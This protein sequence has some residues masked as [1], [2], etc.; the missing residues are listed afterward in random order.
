MRKL[1]LIG[2]VGALL[3]GAVAPALCQAPPAVPAL[4]D[5]ER[6]ISYSISSQTGPFSVTFAL[7]GDG[8]DYQDWLSVT[9]CTS[10]TLNPCSVLVGGTDWTLSSAT[11]SL[12]TIPRPITDA[13]ITLTTARTGTLQ[14]VGARRPRRTSQFAENRGVAARDLN[15]TVTDLVA[16]NREFWDRQNRTILG[17]PGETISALQ[18]ATSRAGGILCWDATGLIPMTCAAGSSG[19]AN[20]VGPNVSVV[21]HIATFGNTSGTLLTDGGLIGSGNVVG[22]S[23]SAST[24]NHAATWKDSGGIN[25][26]DSG[27]TLTPSTGTITITNAKTLAVDN[28]LEFAGTDGTVMTF[29]STSATIARTDA[30]NTFTGHQTIEGVTTT[31]ATGT[32]NLVFA[33]APTLGVVT[34]TS[35]NKVAITAPATS[36]T[37]TIADGKTLTDTSGLGA[38]GLL[39]AAGGGFT[40]YAGS[41][42][43]NQFVRS[44]STAIAA[45]CASVANADLTNSSVTIGSTSVAL[46]TTAA[47]V[48]GLTLT[49]PT[50]NGGTAQALTNLGIRST[51]SGAF[52]MVLQNTENLTAQR[53]LV[54]TLNNAARTIN[55]SGNLTL[56]AGFTTAGGSAITLTATGATNVT[57]PTSGLLAT[58]DTSNTF[59]S[60]NTFSA[61]TQLSDAKFSSG[62]IYPTGDSTTALQ[63]TKADAATVIVDY[64]TTNRRVGINKTPGAFDLDVNGAANVG[65]ALTF[66]IT[67]ITGLT[68]NN[69]PN[70][71]N[72]YLLYFSA[73][74]NAIRKCTVGSCAAAATAGVSSL[75]G[76]TGGLSVAQ[77]TGIA[78]SASGSS[79]TVGISSA[80][81]SDMQTATSTTTVVTPAQTQNHPGVAKAW[82]RFSGTAT[83]TNA[84]SA[85]YNVTSVT[86]NI[87]GDYSVNFTTAFSSTSYVC[88]VQARKAGSLVS[89][90]WATFD[91]TSASVA[92]A[93]VFDSTGTTVDATTVNIAC[94]GAQ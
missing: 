5:S 43:T 19:T 80:S 64:D 75:N 15:Q 6:R 21:G 63:I 84:C 77:G 50:I 69:S 67:T 59:S 58:Q 79:V 48:A 4:P 41:S 34:L 29:P 88:A 1:A 94:W 30:A 38:V 14:I 35:V 68:A 83:G 93:I 16:Q 23:P 49:A 56:A 22:P 82:C 11:G 81:K 70:S 72:D 3:I 37:L 2:I 66:A 57:L 89:A 45:T 61:V 36:A 53:A 91:I 7:Y 18:P 26:K 92:E 60:T 17:Q 87:A 54:L 12:A 40:G 74:D 32:G 42:C 78:V 31:G 28:S 10:A 76:L 39:G 33:T 25:I 27:L 62:K 90:N 13:T 47:T 20:V 55:M 85:G 44:L 24:A 52:D 73:A 46:G 51:G 71:S 65:G 9:L 86:R 8:V